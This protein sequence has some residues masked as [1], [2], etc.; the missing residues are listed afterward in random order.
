MKLASAIV[1]S[2]S[3]ASGTASAQAVAERASALGSP[4]RAPRDR[5]VGGGMA[6]RIGATGQARS[7]NAQLWAEPLTF[8]LSAFANDHLSIDVSMSLDYTFLLAALAAA[9]LT[10][11]PLFWETTIYAD[12]S[13]GDDVR[14]LVGPG[15]GFGVWN[16]QYTH[17]G[18][19]IVVDVAGDAR[20]ALLLGLEILTPGR[21]FGFRVMAR[22]WLGVGAVHS[23][24]GNAL[25]VHGAALLDLGFVFYAD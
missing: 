7:G 9:G 19:P 18:G 5:L 20:L 13:F 21:R 6:F 8:E 15:V 4:T 22:P 2:L 1:L 11:A 23:E 24:A 3:L 25:I 16:H 17:H 10:P 12:W 14:F